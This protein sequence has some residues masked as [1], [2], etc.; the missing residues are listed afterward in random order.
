V[1]TSELRTD[2]R[3]TRSLTV[4]TFVLATAC[5]LT[6]ANLYYGQP[7]LAD[8]ATS[9][10]VSQSTASIAVTAAQAGYALGLVLLLP[11]GD[12]I[13]NRKLAARMLLA[14]AL[15]LVVLASSP[16]FGLFLA[17]TAL[18]GVTSVVAQIL[19]P[20]AAHLAPPAQRGLFV[21]RVMSGLLLGILLARTMSSLIASAW[22]WRSVY[23]IS[24]GFMLVLSAALWQLLPS[25]KPDSTARYPDLLRSLLVLIRTEPVLRRRAVCQALMF[26]AF[27]AFWTSIAYE[28][29]HRHGLSQS[30][31]GIFALVGAGGAL[32]APLAGWLGDRGWSNPASAAAFV[33][34]VLAM[35]IARFGAGQ[36]V[37]LAVAAVLLDLAVQSHQV[38]SQ[39]AIY[40]LRPDA[41]ARLTSVFMGTVFTGG[42]AASAISGQL[43]GHYGWSGVAT[44]SAVL[45]ALGFAVWASGLRPA[46]RTVA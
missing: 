18:I 2:A 24:A 4:L 36:L 30:G 28:L 9:F 5:G 16:D 26:G 1:T 45:A 14:T 10:Q 11:L 35:A 23:L 27:S 21:G 32:A 7:L 41:R 25:R 37:L 15:T 40:A 3:Q 33:L 34:A 31:V 46:A 42:A 22:G 44:F 17:C 12:L 19:V 43:Y 20:F 6:V 13:D 29:V 8:F 39:R 38:L